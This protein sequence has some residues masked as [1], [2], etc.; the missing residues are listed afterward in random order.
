MRCYIYKGIAVHTLPE[1]SWMA[2]DR[3]I[4]KIPHASACTPEMTVFIRGDM[5]KRVLVE[6][7]ILLPAT[8]AVRVFGGKLNMSFIN[9]IPYEHR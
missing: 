3:A 7:I 8:D 2:L 4:S 6:F 5:R 9:V 1:W